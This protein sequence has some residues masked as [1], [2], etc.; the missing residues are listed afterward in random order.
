MKKN[1]WVSPSEKGWKAQRE[2]SDRASRVFAKQK[3]AESY[4]RN[5]LKNSGGGELITQN[6]K[7][8]I[9]SKDTINSN[10]PNP[11]RDKEH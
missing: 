4:A 5:I 7:G 2:G 6:Q 10:D 3:P 1:Y 11:P 9:R 8:R